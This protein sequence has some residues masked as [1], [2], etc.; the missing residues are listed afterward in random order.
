MCVRV[1]VS[2]LSVLALAAPAA[3]QTRLRLPPVEFG[4]RVGATAALIG[5]LPGYGG[6]VTVHVSRRFALE[7]DVNVLPRIDLGVWRARAALYQVGVRGRILRNRKGAEWFWTA[8]GSGAF[9][10][11]QFVGQRP[12]YLFGW[13][14]DLPDGRRSLMLPPVMPTA[15]T[16]LMVPIGSHV[17]VR[18]DVRLL[19]TPLGPLAQ[20][21]VAVTIR[22]D[23]FGR[24]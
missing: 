3:A 21:A 1:C 9:A 6:S 20:T 12:Q 16:G 5:G 8:G 2:V 10:Q 24:R 4:A 17:A 19:V 22:T 18:G 14:V 11:S 23:R 13:T 7:A 15:G